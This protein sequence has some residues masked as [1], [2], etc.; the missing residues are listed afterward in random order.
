MAAAQWTHSLNDIPN[1]LPSA[2]YWIPLPE[3]MIIVVSTCQAR[4]GARAMQPLQVA[5]W[6][7]MRPSW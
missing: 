2:S 1:N 7:L 4:W 3:V 5:D 6:L